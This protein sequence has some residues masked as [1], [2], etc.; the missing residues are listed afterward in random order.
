MKSPNRTCDEPSPKAIGGKL[1][2]VKEFPILAAFVLLC[3]TVSLLSPYFLKSQNIFN[4][5][6]Q[7]SIIGILAVGEALV[8]IT[9][10][11]DLSIGYLLGLCGV[12]TAILAKAGVP[13]P[14]IFIIIVAFGATVSL[15]SGLLV[16]K[17]NINPFIVTLGMMNIFRGVS[18]LITGGMAIQYKSAITVLGSGYIGPV[19]I[20]VIVMFVVVSL[21][22]LFTKCTQ[23]G[24]NVFAVGS[25]MRAAKLSGVNIDATRIMTFVITGALCGLCGMIQSGTLKTSEP[26]AGGGYE[27]D[28]IAAVVIGGTSMSG[29]EGTVLGVI[30]GAAIMGVLKNSFVLLNV[31]AYW[32]IVVL[33]L[34]TI[35]AVAVD[36]LKTKKAA[37]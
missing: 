36:A 4:V 9:G 5:L 11:I 33:G 30:I 32:Q 35:L 14:V 23:P 37:K 13:A 15:M 28:V 31:S 18:L 8:I 2:K 16:T 26:M 24:R 21:G 19:P 10:G 7:F 29:G 25:N 3:L 27:L 34:V 1:H 17:A 6:R 20:P 22:I 12:L